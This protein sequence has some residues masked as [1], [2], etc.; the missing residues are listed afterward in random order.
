M[1]WR[2]TPDSSSGPSSPSSGPSKSVSPGPNGSRHG[3]RRWRQLH[4]VAVGRRFGRERS[5]RGGVVGDRDGDVEFATEGGPESVEQVRGA[6]GSRG[7]PWR[8]RSGP[9]SRAVSSTT[10]DRADVG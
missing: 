5:G 3:R 2:P 1:R 10:A 6:S 8:T 9:T 4:A 7:S